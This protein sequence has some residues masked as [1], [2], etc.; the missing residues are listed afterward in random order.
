MKS[1]A[2]E[3]TPPILTVNPAVRAK[4]IAKRRV[5]RLFLLS[6]ANA[7]SVRGRFLLAD[8]ANSVLGQRL[9][10]EGAPLGEIFSFISGLYFRGKLAYARA[11]AD[12]PPGIPG[13]AVITASGGLV[14]PDQSLTLEEFRRVVMGR[15]DAAESHY[16]LPL[17]RDA[18]LLRDG[19]GTNCE[20]VLLG[21]IATQKYVEPLLGIFGE[22]LRFPAEFVGRGDMS[23][24]G[25]ML[26]CVREHAQLTYVPIIGA[27]RHG[28]RPPKLGKP[29]APGVRVLG[30]P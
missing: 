23:R 24:G 9:R 4:R 8:S 27:A 17:E 16:R 21:S 1:K 28:E 22:S 20:V 3:A 19:M 15:V 30:S 11:Y 7:S 13:I 26:R 14:S 10:N 29:A 25:L 12:P 6:P 2:N 18:R 5:R